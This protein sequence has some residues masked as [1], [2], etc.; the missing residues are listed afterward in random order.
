MPRHRTL[1]NV[2]HRIMKRFQEL[3]LK[4]DE[5]FVVFVR[6]PVLI[7]ARLWFLFLSF[8]VYSKFNLCVC[9]FTSYCAVD[10][11]IVFSSFLQGKL[12]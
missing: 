2:G 12:N 9:F 11:Y 6:L 1:V 3:D 8:F 7:K 4:V 5:E 10:I